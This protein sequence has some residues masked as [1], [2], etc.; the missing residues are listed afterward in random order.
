MIIFQGWGAIVGLI[1][2]GL[3]GAAFTGITGNDA[4]GGVVGGLVLTAFGF[5]FNVLGGESYRIFWIPIQ[6]IGILA[7]LGS[8]IGSG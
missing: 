7:V 3:I 2:A 5:F 1:G 6:Y 4:V 8:L